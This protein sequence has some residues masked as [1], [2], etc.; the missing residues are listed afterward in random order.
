MQQLFYKYLQIM[1]LRR[2]GVFG[3]VTVFPP[4]RNGP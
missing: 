3:T 1:F 4:G 2:G